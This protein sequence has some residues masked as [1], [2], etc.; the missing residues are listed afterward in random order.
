MNLKSIIS[1][2]DEVIAAVNVNELLGA[3]QTA[4]SD[5]KDSASGSGSAADK[6]Y[7]GW[8]FLLVCFED[9]FSERFISSN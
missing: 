7:K 5:K 6:L 4:R 1:H 3:L 9:F 8:D 2:A